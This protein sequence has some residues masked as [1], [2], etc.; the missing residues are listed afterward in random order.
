[1]RTF[2]S[3]L[4]SATVLG[5]ALLFGVAP[6]ATGAQEIPT[7]ADARALV[8]GVQ[9]G[10]EGELSVHTL[11]ALMEELGV[12][13]V[14]IAVIHD[15]EVAWARGYGI[16][17]VETMARVDVETMFQAASISKPVAAMGSMVAVQ[18]GVFGL[19]D[20]VN[21]ILTSWALDG[22][23]FTNEHAVTPRMLRA[24]MPRSA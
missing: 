8:E 11:E 16:A 12:P 19:D 4:L 17:D 23:G 2:K 21:D 6:R 1:M 5:A 24:A 10:V 7:P 15:F 14:S 22:E 20:D 18:E 9:E 13:G 3:G